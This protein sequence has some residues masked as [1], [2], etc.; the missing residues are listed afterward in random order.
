MQIVIIG[1]LLLHSSYATDVS[2]V[3]KYLQ[4]FGYLGK[5]ENITSF[6]DRSIITALSLFQKRHRL[7]DDGKL[8]NETLDLL[9]KPRCGLEDNP[10]GYRLHHFKWPKSSLTWKFYSSTQGPINI[11]TAA[12]AEW[13]RHSGLQFREVLTGKPNISISF[14]TKGHMRMESRENCPHDLDGLGNV[15]AHTYYPEPGKTTT[16]IHLDSDEPWHYELTQ[17][18]GKISLYTVLMHEIG[19]GILKTKIR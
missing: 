11:A 17:V 6:D 12:F 15:L 7:N 2:Y 10:F 16:E 3:V 18:P 13:Q 5:N 14:R 9:K 1:L 19:H 4:R 8:N